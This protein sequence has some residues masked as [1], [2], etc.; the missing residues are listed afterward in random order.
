MR[1][2]QKPGHFSVDC[3]VLVSAMTLRDLADPGDLLIPRRRRDDIADG[4]LDCRH[5]SRSGSAVDNDRNVV[6]FVTPQALP[7]SLHEA[8]VDLQAAGAA[9]QA[10]GDHSRRARSGE[11]VD[12]HAAFRRACLDEKLREPLGHGG[13]VTASSFVLVICL[14]HGDYIA[15]IGAS[16]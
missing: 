7:R 1:H 12:D 2:I 14:W 16:V 8:A 10:P 5:D 6:W 15:R 4:L 13:G 11:R 9:A 3:R